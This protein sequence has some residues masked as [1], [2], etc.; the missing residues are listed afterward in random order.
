MIAELNQKLFGNK[1]VV[2]EYA[3]K[4]TLVFGEPTIFRDFGPWL[5]GKAVLDIG[6][7][8][9]RTTPHLLKFEPRRYVGVDF[10]VGM[11]DHCRQRFPGTDFR[12]ADARS[13]T[14][15]ADGEFDFVLFSWS[16]IDCVN[17]EDRLRILA[18]VRR[19]LVPGG[20]FIFSSAN[21]RTL[22]G[23]PWSRAVLADLEVKVSIRSVVRGVRDFLRCTRN[24]LAQKNE[25]VFSDEYVINLDA[26]HSFQLLR[27]NIAPD[28]QA[29]QLLAAA[30]SDVRA[31]DKQGVYRDTQDA[32]LTETPI[33]YICNKS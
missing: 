6:V 15:F 7:G 30:F 13:L 14:D 22:C 10:A 17:H 26:A 27:Y 24:Y 9:G 12:F 31:V 1:S 16:G 25:Q 19:V 33:Y 11:L 32:T 8:A 3:Y 18:E 5:K 29:A 4:T 28:K 20:L 23:P 2:S 21:A